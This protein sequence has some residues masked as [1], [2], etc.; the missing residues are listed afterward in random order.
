MRN[1][2]PGGDES[3]NP[4]P[5][6]RRAGLRACCWRPVS[7]RSSGRRWPRSASPAIICSGSSTTFWTFRNWR[8]AAS[9]SKPSISHRPPLSRRWL[10]VIRTLPGNKGLTVQVEIDPT[11]PRSLRGDA[12]NPPGAAQLASNAMK[13]TE[14]GGVT[15]AVTCHSRGACWHGSSGACQTPASA[16]RRIDEPYV[17]GFCSGRCLDESPLRRHGP[18]PCDLRR[19]IEQMGGAIAVSSV[20]DEG[21]TFRFSLTLPWNETP[22]ADQK[23]D[24]DGI[25]I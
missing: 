14:R 3:R 5:H 17:Q 22:V 24:G 18:R 21:S 10:P 11:L 6:E 4:H 8:P 1:R 16:S 25:N 19:I 12:A 7:I 20:P 9:S 13:F 23:T 15:I 2:I